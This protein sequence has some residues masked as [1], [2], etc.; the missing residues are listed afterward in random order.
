MNLARTADSFRDLWPD[1]EDVDI[2]LLA[3][4]IHAIASIHRKQRPQALAELMR[5]SGAWR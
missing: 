4:A 2:C 5:L 1:W 3:I